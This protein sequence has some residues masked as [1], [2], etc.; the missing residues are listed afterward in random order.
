[1]QKKI[2][3]S[4]IH[5]SHYPNGNWKSQNFCNNSAKSGYQITWHENGNIKSSGNF[6]NNKPTGLHKFWDDNGCLRDE[7]ICKDGDAFTLLSGVNKVILVGNVVERNVLNIGVSSGN[8]ATTSLLIATS[9]W[10]TDKNTGHKQEKTEWHRI[11]IFGELAEYAFHCYRGTKVYIEGSLQTNTS[12]ENTETNRYASEIIVSSPN[13]VI[14]RLDPPYVDYV[15][16]DTVDI[17]DMA[18]F[19]LEP[20]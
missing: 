5:G 14:E 7:I 12:L 11:T 1:M 4:T 19:D 16:P 9:E 10:W 2:L 18:N 17:D 20:F 3:N 8:V 15:D 13:G 6:E